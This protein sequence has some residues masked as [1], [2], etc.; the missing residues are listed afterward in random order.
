MLEVA[1]NAFVML[2]VTIGPVEVAPIFVALTAHFAPA[3]RRK[4]A[5]AATL[6][7]TGIL[8]AFALAGGAL[9]QELGVSMAAFRISGGILLLLLAI[10]LIFARQTGLSSITPGEEREAKHEHHIA[11]VPLGIPLLAGPGAVAAIVLLMDRADGRIEWQLATLG[12]LMAVMALTLVILLAAERLTLLLGITGV[13]VIARVAGIILSALAVQFILDGLK[14][15]GVT[16][17]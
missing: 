6:T 3:T 9:L 4:L 10:D 2:A 17:G 13:K 7:A 14:A 8:L 12:A 15:A 1:I 16:A 5:F 11:I